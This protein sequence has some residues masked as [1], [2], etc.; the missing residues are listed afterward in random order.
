MANLICKLVGVRGR[1]MEV[2]DTKCVIKT[3]VTVVSG[4]VFHDAKT[5][6]VVRKVGGRV[7]SEAEARNKE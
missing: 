5:N 2:Y 3:D 1:T 4:L 7:V 6:D